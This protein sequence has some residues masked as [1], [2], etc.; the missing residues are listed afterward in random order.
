MDNVDVLIVGSGAAGSLFAA[1][2]AQAG[3]SVLILEGGPERRMEDLYSSQIWSRRLKWGGPPTETG[4]NDPLS[5][6]FGSGWGTGGS[7]T[8]HFAVWLRLHQEDFEL[9]T[10]FG[11]GLDWPIS[12]D[13]LR[14]YYDQIQTEV[15]ISGD[16]DAEVWRPP[17]EP[18]PMP[19]LQVFNQGKLISRG[20]EKLGGRTS[21]L[22]LAINS[23][24]YNGRA[25]KSSAPQGRMKFGRVP[26]CRCM[27]WAE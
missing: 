19:P 16:A 23:Q 10:R 2:L 3:R 9:R 6:G 25:K 17:G 12:Y 11:Q 15:G 7:A 24:E 4:G 13:D 18:Y 5:V 8:H 21:P 1:K 14:P 27:S 26:A 22:P 20:F